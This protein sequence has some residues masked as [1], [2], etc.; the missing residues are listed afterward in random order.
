MS[1]GVPNGLVSGG[2]SLDTRPHEPD[3]EAR[4]SKASVQ[5]SGPASPHLLPTPLIRGFRRKIPGRT[6]GTLLRS[7]GSQS[8]G[9]SSMA[10]ANSAPLNAEPAQPEEREKQQL[11][12]KSYADAVEQEPP[13]K[14]TNGKNDA[15][16]T[17]G[18]NENRAEHDGSKQ[19]GHKA[20][21][22][23]IVDTGAPDTND[24]H[25][26][27]PQIERQESKHEYSATV[28]PNSLS[29]SL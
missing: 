20:S 26:D 27:R 18:S 23:R 2:E 14:G 25:G 4:H 21:V 6:E 17:L 28:C 22:L 11:P 3:R 15:N 13:A 8:S 29:L 24:K 9:Q 19:T 12:P 7:T 16:G 5:A 10:A 1:T